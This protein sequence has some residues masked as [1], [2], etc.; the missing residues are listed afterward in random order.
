MK[1]LDFGPNV[2]RLTATGNTVGTHRYMAPE[3]HDS[4]PITPR[5][6]LYEDMC[7]LNGEDHKEP[8]PASGLYPDRITDSAD[9]TTPV[10][11]RIGRARHHAGR[12][13]E[14]S[15]GAWAARHP[16]P[17]APRPE[18]PGGDRGTPRGAPAG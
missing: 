4:G 13:R 11:R 7:Y 18:S 5:T 3:Q 15:V 16:E 6:D 12:S 17:R 1:V 14:S 2:T 10:S 9:G 8:R